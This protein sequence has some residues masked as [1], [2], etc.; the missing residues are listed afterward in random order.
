MIKSKP[1]VNMIMTED[2]DALRDAL[3]SSVHAYS[4]AKELQELND[5]FDWVYEANMNID[6]HNKTGE[7]SRW[8]CR[9]HKKNVFES[10]D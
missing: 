9:R 5:V 3:A 10:F 7:V 4:L 2:L 8:S 6:K 1:I